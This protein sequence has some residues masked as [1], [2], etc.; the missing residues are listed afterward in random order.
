[1]F[2]VPDLV[3][4]SYDSQLIITYKI[5]CTSKAIGGMLVNFMSLLSF[6]DLFFG[7]GGGGE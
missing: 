7:G 6:V 4:L 1:M 5:H 3:S 2:I